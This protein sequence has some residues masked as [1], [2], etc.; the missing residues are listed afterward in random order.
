MNISFLIG[1]GFSI[2][3]GMPS[4]CDINKMFTSIKQ[5]KIYYG[6]D[7]Y[8]T[9]LRGQDDPNGWMKKDEKDFFVEFIADYCANNGGVTG[10]NY[11]DFFDY[12][13]AHYRGNPDPA[14]TQFCHSFRAKT[15]NKQ[16]TDDANLLL[17]FHN[18]FS[19][20]LAA[21][22]RK[23]KL[24]ENAVHHMNYGSYDVFI[25]FID[26]LIIGGQTVNLHTLNHDLLLD[27][28]CQST[29]LYSE[30]CDGFSEL[31]SPYYGSL[32]VDKELEMD[33][34]ETKIKMDYKVRVKQYI[35][36][37]EKRL[38]LYKL[39]GSVDNH[40]FISTRPPIDNPKLV[41]STYGVFDF[42]KEVTDPASGSLLYQHGY[43]ESFPSFLSGTTTKMSQY[44][45]P[46]YSEMLTHFEDNLRNCKRLIIIGYGF[47]DDGINQ[48]I[49][50][51]CLSRGIVPLVISP[52]PS[53]S[54]FYTSHTFKFVPKGIQQISVE[55]FD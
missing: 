51:H 45:E 30:Y 21:M 41:K 47:W 35:D 9:F 26:S 24:Y 10:F 22:L 11:E 39:H 4:V 13:Y 1:S 43:K 3:Y 23:A 18:I 33:G 50:D 34:V 42:W 15:P 14:I 20:L 52:S 6:S 12:Y 8:V 27:H 37:F 38:R 25:S 32:K 7:R 46:F 40:W 55:D 44:G 17:D 2:P 29:G 36:S 48:R 49:E 19:Q 28:M 53:Q 5:D 54:Q 16:S 31:G